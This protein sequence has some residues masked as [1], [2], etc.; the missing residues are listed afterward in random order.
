MKKGTK[1]KKN[2]NKI[3]LSKINKNPKLAKRK[4]QRFVKQ[5]TNQ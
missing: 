3:K 4:I 5:G 1:L 2:F